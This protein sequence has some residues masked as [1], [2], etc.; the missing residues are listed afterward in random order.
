MQARKKNGFSLANPFL[1]LKSTASNSRL[2][3][4]DFDLGF[5]KPISKNT[6]LLFSFYLI[7]SACSLE[8][9]WGLNDFLARVSVE[10][11]F[12]IHYDFTLPANPPEGSK[13][14]LD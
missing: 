4:S 2:H 10:A 7:S 1:K 13:K 14:R 11:S 9:T 8:N 12:F 5:K 3:L 6:V